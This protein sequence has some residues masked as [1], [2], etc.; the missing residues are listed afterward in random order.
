M[1]GDKPFTHEPY[2]PVRQKVNGVVNAA[3]Q[4]F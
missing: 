3:V 2:L 1:Q 4:N